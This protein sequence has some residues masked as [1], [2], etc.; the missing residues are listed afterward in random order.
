[1]VDSN[2]IGGTARDM[3]GRA[4]ET[5][6]DTIGDARMRAHG[7]A[8]QGYG[9]AQHAAGEAADMIRGQPLT[10]ALIALG[11]GFVI[12]RLTR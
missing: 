7:M 5:V 4:Q 3:A 6:G 11:V 9:Q 2:T 12:G 1:M 10:A 8:N